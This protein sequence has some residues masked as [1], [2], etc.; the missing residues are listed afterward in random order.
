MSKS[1]PH[2]LPS[3]ALIGMIH[4]P[5]LPGTPMNRLSVSEI[6]AQCRKEA[7]IYAEAGVEVIL[8]ENM[9]DVPYLPREVGPEIIAMMTRCATVVKEA[10]G[11]PVGIQVLAGANM[12]ALAVAQAAGCDFIRAEGFVFGHVADEGYLNADAGALLRHRKQIGAEHISIFTD[13]KKKHSSHAITSD[14][15]LAE[16]AK[17]AAFF[18]SDGLIVTGIATGAPAKPADV[19]QVAQATDLPVLIG[20][21]ISPHNIAD[22]L[23]WTDAFIVGS[24]IKQ[25]G[26]WQR[27]PDPRR[28]K[29]LKR[30]I[31]G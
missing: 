30:A 26:N 21:G 10:S 25:D 11:L 17:A 12:A 3:K 29:E 18:L 4:V 8:V 15:D 13:I 14:V 19:Q 31:R 20:S 1:L 16:T 28:I 23:P 27:E 5:A 9:H 7:E 24:W 2:W 6:I 22:Y